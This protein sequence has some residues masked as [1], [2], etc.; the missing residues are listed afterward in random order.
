MHYRLDP[1]VL[2]LARGGD[3]E[4]TQ[5]AA[6]L[7]RLAT[8]LARRAAAAAAAAQ[9]CYGDEAVRGTAHHCAVVGRRTQ[10]QHRL[11][12]QCAHGQ[13]RAG[14]AAVEEA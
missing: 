4:P 1:A 10:A 2:R 12:V 11:T 9:R 3:L 7:G 8:R 13:G 6:Q 5:R 14:V